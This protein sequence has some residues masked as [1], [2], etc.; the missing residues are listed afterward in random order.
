M[1]VLFVTNG[2]PPS[3]IAGTEILAR[4]VAKHFLGN[5]HEVTVFAPAYSHE[6]ENDSWV[7]GI[8]IHC[9]PRPS[10]SRYSFTYLD[11]A[12]DLKFASFLLEAKPEVAIVWHTINLSA[13]ILEVLDRM[14]VPFILYL[15]DF[16]F[17]CNQTHLLTAAMEQCDGPEEGTKCGECIAVAVANP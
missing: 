4:R 11:G 16:H 3:E 14:A 12:V 2:F 10:G 13:R 17:L 15:S 1:R 9:V 6:Q 7:E 8:R 5:G